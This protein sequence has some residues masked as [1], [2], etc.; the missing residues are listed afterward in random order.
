METFEELRLAMINAE[1]RGLAYNS[2]FGM[3]SEPCTYW[4]VGDYIVTYLTDDE[5]FNAEMLTE[6][7]MD[8]L[9]I[10]ER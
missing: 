2:V 5:D 6:D 10:E 7:M 9:I 1:D 4:L 3:D 8:E